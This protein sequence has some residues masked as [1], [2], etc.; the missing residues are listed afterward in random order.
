MLFRSVIAAIT[1]T[2]AQHEVV[3]SYFIDEWKISRPKATVITTLLAGLLGT[4]AA[5]S[6]GVWSGYTLFDLRFFDVLDKFT[7]NILLPLGGFFTTI[8][9][10]WIMDRKL[11]VNQITSN[12]ALKTT[13]VP[14]IILLLKYL[15]PL[16]MLIIVFDNLGIF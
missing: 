15:C 13:L 5:L 2:I 7:A 9:V 8:Y 6:L 3:T 10:G 16:M 1:S 11:F 4:V 12:G 14:I